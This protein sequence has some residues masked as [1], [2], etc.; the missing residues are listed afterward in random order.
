M[1]DIIESTERPNLLPFLKKIQGYK[2]GL[3]FSKLELGTENINPRS[4]FIFVQR[5]NLMHVYD[6]YTHNTQSMLNESFDLKEK[7][8][9]EKSA[10]KV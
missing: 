4:M 2:I 8:K 5:K 7:K 1:S 3:I 9:G 10:R 6:L